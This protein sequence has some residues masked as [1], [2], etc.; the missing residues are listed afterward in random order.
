[1]NAVISGSLERR[2][3]PG[4][5]CREARPWTLLLFLPAVLAG[6]RRPWLPADFEPPEGLR[7]ERFVIRPIAVR[8][9]DAD[10]EAVVES[11]DIIHKALLT[12]RWP[13]ADF[14]VEEDRRQI[15]EK[16]RHARKRRRFT[17][18]VLTPGEDRVLGSIY[19]YPGIG[20]PDAAVFLWVRAS[21]FEE[22]LDST[23]ERVTREWIRSDWPFK[24]VVF[25][26]RGGP[27]RQKDASPGTAPDGAGTDQP[28][29]PSRASMNRDTG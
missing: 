29:P 28:P 7:T 3:R 18:A 17:Y 11:V 9:A 26:G 4:R 23:L 8:D 21:A 16:E 27:I 6:C 10:Y 19:V 12:D 14:T 25:P 13:P 22:G 24:W 20:G 15:E 1:M 2:S 5:R